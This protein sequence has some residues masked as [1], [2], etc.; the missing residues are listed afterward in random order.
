V[1]VTK[2]IEVK[3]SRKRGAAAGDI[4]AVMAWLSKAFEKGSVSTLG[5][6]TD[7]GIA[8]TGKIES[9]SLVEENQ[10]NI[11]A[12]GISTKDDF[13]SQLI[14][15]ATKH[16][17]YGS[18]KVHNL[19]APGHWTILIPEDLTYRMALKHQKEADARLSRIAAEAIGKHEALR[20]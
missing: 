16:K 10:G 14:L 13:E 9:Y 11:H 3:L 7:S 12:E 20:S 15:E 17:M 2:G 4:A 1:G 18:I 5:F 8:Y 19:D 6:E